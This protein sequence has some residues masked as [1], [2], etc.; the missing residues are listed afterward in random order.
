M[1]INITINSD[2]QKGIEILSKIVGEI[3]TEKEIVDEGKE[4]FIKGSWRG[5]WYT[6]RCWKG[7]KENHTS[8]HIRRNNE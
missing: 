4:T 2:L 8:I 6:I 3:T 5:G 7:G 1:E